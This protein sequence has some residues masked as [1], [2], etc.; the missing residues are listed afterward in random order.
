MSRSTAVS[1][2]GNIALNASTGNITFTGTLPIANGG[3]NTN[4]NGT[5]AL[6]DENRHV[7]YAPVGFAQDSFEPGRVLPLGMG[8]IGSV[9][10]IPV[11]TPNGV[12]NVNVHVANLTCMGCQINLF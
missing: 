8:H 2:S 3:T 7:L 10:P 5:G 4:S 12:I 6:N 11:P 9:P 1:A